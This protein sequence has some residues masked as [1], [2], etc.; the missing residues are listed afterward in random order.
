LPHV[1]TFL[2]VKPSITIFFL[3]NFFLVSTCDTPKVQPLPFFG[4]GGGGDG[5]R[6]WEEEQRESDSQRKIGKKLE[7][8]KSLA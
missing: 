4:G 6:R 8:R 5:N 3:E 7:A 2:G 1:F